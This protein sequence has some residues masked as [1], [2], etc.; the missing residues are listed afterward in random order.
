MELREIK[1][2]YSAGKKGKQV[3]SSR[4]AYEV[5]KPIFND[6]MEHREKSVCLYLNRAN[7]VLGYFTLGIGGVAGVIM[8]LKIAFQVGLKCNASGMIIA[9]NHPSGNLSP[10]HNDKKV[11]RK[12]KEAGEIIDLAVLDSLILTTQGYYSLSDEGDF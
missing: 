8:D 3:T 1:V 4:D 12:F 5:L 2:S 10:S 11:S 6:G 7:E 9:H